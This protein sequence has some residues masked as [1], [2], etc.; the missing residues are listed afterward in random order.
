MSGKT[1]WI[2]LMYRLNREQRELDEERFWW[3]LHR[4]SAERLNREVQALAFQRR[5]AEAEKG[6]AG[7]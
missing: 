2:S 4:Q 6:E 7:R 3:Q 5:A 1:A